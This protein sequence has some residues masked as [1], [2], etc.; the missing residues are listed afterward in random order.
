MSGS[1]MNVNVDF[2]KGIVSGAPNPQRVA[3]DRG[4]WD[5]QVQGQCEDALDR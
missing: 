5:V 3:P 2:N 4:F 1:V